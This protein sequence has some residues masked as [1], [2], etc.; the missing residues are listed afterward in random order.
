MA[1]AHGPRTRRGH[2]R[3]AQQAVTPALRRQ[4]DAHR[5]LRAAELYDLAALLEGYGLTP[6]AGPIRDAAGRCPGEPR[7]VRGDTPDAGRLVWGYQIDGLRL[8]LKE[9]RRCRPR[10]AEVEALEGRLSVTVE[11]FVP[12][13]ADKVEQVYDNVRRLDASFTL[14][15]EL[16]VNGERHP[17]RSAWHVDTHLFAGEASDGVHPRFHFQFGGKNFAH[18]DEAI[19]GV[20]LSEAP[21]LA[22]APLDGV[23]AIDFVLSHYAGRVWDDLSASEPQYG[24]LRTPAM[25]RYWQPYYRLL[26]DACALATPIAFGSP[27]A[28]LLLNLAIA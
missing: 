13:C 12:D 3:E 20:L 22:C 25:A 11:E 16:L 24:R 23:L 9:Q 10:A 7:Q 2:D 1:L 28:A 27:A 26:A 5:A 18:L 4:F 15:A 6:D 8:R 17:L 21:R 19:R 14:D